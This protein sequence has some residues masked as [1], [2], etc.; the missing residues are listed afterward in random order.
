[1]PRKGPHKYGPYEK[2]HKDETLLRVQARRLLTKK[3][4]IAALKGK[5]VDH[6]VSIKS[7]GKNTPGNLRLRS[8]R[9]NRGDKTF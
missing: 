2:A 9:A 7:G 5:D 6:R 1:M 8:P 3:M 4:G